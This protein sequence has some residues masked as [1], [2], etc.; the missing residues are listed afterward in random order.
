MSLIARQQF[1]STDWVPEEGGTEDTPAPV[2]EGGDNNG[3]SAAP[4][5]TPAVTAPVDDDDD[6]EEPLD[7]GLAIELE[8]ESPEKK[9]GEDEEDEEEEPELFARYLVHTPAA[10]AARKRPS[11]ST[12]SASG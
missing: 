3:P 4:T 6:A 2:A 10:G 9:R 7:S 5:P 8:P 12:I 11:S 1:L